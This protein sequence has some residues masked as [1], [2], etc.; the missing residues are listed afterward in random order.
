[1]YTVRDAEAS[2][3]L[4]VRLR[5]LQDARDKATLDDLSGLVRR[6]QALY[7]RSASAIEDAKAACAKVDVLRAVTQTGI[8]SA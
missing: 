4:T 2:D 7:G 3:D 8:S 6:L 5:R 1:M